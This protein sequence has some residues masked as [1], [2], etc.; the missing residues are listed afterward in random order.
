MTLYLN[1]LPIEFSGGVFSGS[2][3][4]FDDN[5]TLVSELTK[6]REQHGQTHYFYRKGNCILCIPLSDASI[7]FG[8][9]RTF[10]AETDFQLANALARNALL[11]SFVEE[12]RV[13]SALRPSSFVRMDLELLPANTDILSAYPEYRFDVRPIAPHEGPFV[14]GIL[15]DF[16]TRRM[17]HV[18]AA[19]LAERGVDLRG[20]YVQTAATDESPYVDHRFRRRLVG[21]ILEIRGDSAVLVD[22]DRDSVR[23]DSI[24]VEPTGRN[25]EKI[26]QD[27][28]LS[29]GESFWKAF[30]KATFRV[31]GAENQL[32]RI[33]SIGQWLKE[34]GPFECCPDLTV[35]IAPK[36]FECA[37]GNEAGT[38]RIFNTPNCVLR[39]GGNPTVPWPVD[40]KIDQYG[41][42]DAELFPDKRVNVAVLCPKGFVGEVESFLASL[43]DGMSNTRFRQGLVRKYRLN[44]CS[45]DVHPLEDS[46]PEEYRKG[47]IKASRSQPHLA[48]IVVRDRDRSLKGAENPYFVAKAA[49]MSQGVPVQAL[50]IE[51]VRTAAN[52]Y[53]FNNLA[54]ASYAKLGG[55]PWVLESSPGLVHEIV[56]GIG[57]ARIQERRLSGSD[58]LVGITTVFSGDG[59]YLLASHTREVE[60]DQYSEELTSTL[61]E[62]IDDLRRRYGWK[63]G[64][65]VRLIFHQSFK[66]YKDVEAQAVE[67]FISTLS[68]F[69]VEY[70]FVHLSD[71][72]NWKLFDSDGEGYKGKG[73]KVPNRGIYVPLGPHAGLLTLTG[74][75]QIKTPI[76][77]CPTPLLI[78][79]HSNSSFKSLDYIAGQVFKLTFMSW[80][81]FFPST[82]PVSLSYSNRIVSLLGNLRS[83][84]HWNPDTLSTGLR[85]KRWFL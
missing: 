40:Q 56:V 28:K 76:Q 66:K 2:E 18:D 41:P 4:V 60:F 50:K 13:I 42:Y 32:D 6:L 51:T 85:E 61:S 80:R 3:K 45:F 68:N 20:L 47:V 39:P 16:R 44:S 30:Q 84:P 55:V 52:P 23:L 35:N 27:L 34:R 74:P 65:R 81:N 36:L 72:H 62:T 12:G 73:I 33:G 79:I 71:S 58:R 43:R 77:G 22:S 24:F 17:I 8:T 48:V 69:E 53:T 82:L 5:E 78:S 14:N 26:G 37:R 15:V 54:L 29:R 19:Q 7:D 21:K 31:S 49:F 57:S 46:S 9:S 67:R 59:N 83:V 64:D 70:A 63:S 11:R 10:N 75:G 1:Y 38:Q 25:F